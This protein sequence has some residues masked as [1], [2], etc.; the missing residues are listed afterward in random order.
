MQELCSTWLNLKCDLDLGSCNGLKWLNTGY[1]NAEK[2]LVGHNK[3]Y[4]LQC[5]SKSYRVIL[6]PTTMNCS[7]TAV[8]CHSI[9]SR[10]ISSRR[11]L[12]EGGSTKC[13][14]Y[15]SVQGPLWK[16]SQELPWCKTPCQF[17]ICQLMIY[18][19]LMTYNIHISHLPLCIAHESKEEK[20]LVNKSASSK[21]SWERIKSFLATERS[22][23]SSPSVAYKGLV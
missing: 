10:S 5:F 13:V 11:L 4:L 21:Q 9:Q 7:Y 15:L 23:T 2:T 19:V 22:W 6:H 8:A 1:Y 3:L 20:K 16:F 18:Y 17:K 14:Q 12:K